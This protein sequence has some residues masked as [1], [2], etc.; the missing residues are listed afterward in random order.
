M[1]IF[2]VPKSELAATENEDSIEDL[3]LDR[4]GDE[5]DADTDWGQFVEAV[6]YSSDEDNKNIDDGPQSLDDSENGKMSD[7]FSS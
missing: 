5:D 6:R 2:A 3:N 4:I 1:I 7:P